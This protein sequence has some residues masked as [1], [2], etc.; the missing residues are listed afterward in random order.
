[1]KSTW[2]DLILLCTFLCVLVILAM[3]ILVFVQAFKFV[4]SVVSITGSV[5]KVVS[6][7]TEFDIQNIAAQIKQDGLVFKIAEIVRDFIQKRRASKL[8][9]EDEPK[10]TA[11][12]A[13]DDAK[14]TA[15][16]STTDDYVN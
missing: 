1:M 11:E 8:I 3:L 10:S 12:E 2:G 16:Q 7:L 5:D 9:I 4:R 14:P 15:H 13:T 6:T